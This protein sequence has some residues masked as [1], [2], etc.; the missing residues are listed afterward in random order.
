MA[1]ILVVCLP[2]ALILLSIL[3]KLTKG[4]FEIRLNIDEN[5]SNYFDTVDAEDRNWS[6]KEE[7][8]LRKEYVIN[9]FFLIL[10]I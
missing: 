8:H 3:N 9:L 5:L 7:N 1:L 4:Y 10:F 2:T 6:I